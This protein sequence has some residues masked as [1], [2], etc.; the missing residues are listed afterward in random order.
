VERKVPDSSARVRARKKT[1]SSINKNLTV[2]YL[3]LLSDILHRYENWK[4]NLGYVE[5]VIYL[6]QYFDYIIDTTEVAGS[7]L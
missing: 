5:L 2:R 4:Y 1:Y 3:L 7:G 6:S